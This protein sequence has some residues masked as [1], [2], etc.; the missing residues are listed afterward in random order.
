MTWQGVSNDSCQVTDGVDVTGIDV[1]ITSS[2]NFN[3][4][5]ALGTRSLSFFS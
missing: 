3:G 2:R 4:D 5:L 1:S